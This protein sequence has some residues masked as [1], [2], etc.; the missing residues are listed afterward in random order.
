MG[1]SSHTFIQ[2]LR[3]RSRSNETNRTRSLSEEE[4]EEV[5]FTA[6][7]TESTASAILGKGQ[8]LTLCTRCICTAHSN[9]FAPDSGVVSAATSENAG[10]TMTCDL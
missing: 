5:R 8:Y 1:Y 6:R 2:E 10:M 7:T 4:E 3:G 9:H